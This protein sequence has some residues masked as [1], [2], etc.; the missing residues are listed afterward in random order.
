MSSYEAAVG[1]L[2]QQAGKLPSLDKI[3]KKE[4]DLLLAGWQKVRSI[5][6]GKGFQL[7]QKLMKQVQAQ[8]MALMKARSHGVDCIMLGHSRSLIY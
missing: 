8:Q 2:L 7:P 3:E 5:A 4:L 6:D 1:V